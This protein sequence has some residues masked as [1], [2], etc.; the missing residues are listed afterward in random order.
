MSQVLRSSAVGGRWN[1]QHDWLSAETKVKAMNPKIRIS[2]MTVF[3][4]KKSEIEKVLPSVKVDGSSKTGVNAIYLAFT[5]ALLIY[6][7]T[8]PVV[9]LTT[10][11][12]PS[13]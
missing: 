11:L 12:L 8:A 4:I 9:F 1:G 5:V 6:C 13:C 7:F 10:G 2:L 3:E